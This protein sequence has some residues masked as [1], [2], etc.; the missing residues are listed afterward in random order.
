MFSRRARWGLAVAFWSFVT[1]LYGLQIWWLARQPG[2]SIQLWRALVWQTTFYLS[3]IPFTVAIWDLTRRWD[4]SALGWKGL[5]ARHGAAMLAVSVVQ[6]LVVVLIGS[7]L[8]GMPGERPLQMF[9]GQLRGRIYFNVIIYA[10]IA[11]AG[12]ALTLYAHRRERDAHAATLA[13]Q[14]ASARLDAL[15]AQLHPHFLFNSLHAI[16]SLVRDGRNADAVR[17][18]SGMS[19]LLRRVLETDTRELQLAEEL[20]LVRK[21]VEIQQVRFGDRLQVQIDSDE[22]ASATM[23]PAL[24]VQPLVENAVRHGVSPRIEGGRI[25]IRA[26]VN[27][28]H[29]VVEVEDDGPGVPEGWSIPAARGHGT[30]LANLRERLQALYGQAAD[31]A[32]GRAASGGVLVTAR[33]PR[34]TA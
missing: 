14:L 5:L 27:Q 31:L 8:A 21:Y 6:T 28:S 7:A 2:E 34:R 32:V 17:L 22:P 16:S 23:V 9:V 15:R 29:L 13:A 26:R 20:D 30:G 24:L 3:W 1:L 18:I 11:A 4:P 10:G 25:H 33:I 19:D 12:Y